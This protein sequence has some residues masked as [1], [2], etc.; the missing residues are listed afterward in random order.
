MKKYS[1]I[2]P[3]WDDQSL[4]VEQWLEKRGFNLSFTKRMGDQVDFENSL[5]NI[6]PIKNKEE[7]FYTLLHECGHILAE[8]HN[9][10]FKYNYKTKD[11]GDWD[12]MMNTRDSALKISILADEMEAWNRG[13]KLAYRLELLVDVKKYKK[14]AGQCVWSYA[15]YMTL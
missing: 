13:R 15:H 5:I 11:F 3:Y 2:D 4:I 7:M 9:K 12:K 10:N 1:K 8:Q 14:L 6:K